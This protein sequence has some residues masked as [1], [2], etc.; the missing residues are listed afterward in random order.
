MLVIRTADNF[1]L[2]FSLVFLLVLFKSCA[3]FSEKDVKYTKD[4]IA[5]FLLVT[6]IACC[7]RWK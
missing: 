5:T 2:C 1:M 3:D 4:Y 6:C 7:N